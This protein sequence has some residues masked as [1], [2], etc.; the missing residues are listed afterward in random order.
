MDD[1]ER[2]EMARE[3]RTSYMQVRRYP[4]VVAY[5]P[6][7]LNLGWPAGEVVTG[8]TKS[9]S[10]G[11]LGLLLDD[12]IPLRTPVWVQV[13]QDEPLSGHIIWRD[14]PTPTDLGIRIAHGVAFDCPVEGDRIR[15]WASE[16]RRQ[17]HPR[18]Q[19]QFD[20]EFIQAGETR[21][22][23]CLNLSRAGMFIATPDPPRPGTEI[24][25]QFGVEDVSYPLSIPAKVVWVHGEEVAAS[26]ITGMGVKFLG[27]K[28]SAATF[29]ADVIDRGRRKIPASHDPFPSL[30][31]SG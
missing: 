11:G 29:I 1:R 9:I 26:A 25:L 8:K 31:P 10:A 22:G 21:P 23:S 28:P 6:T 24:L 4:R 18:R 13:A 2:E 14:R 27:L 16:S 20:L 12:M 3:P 19:V 7:T 15:Q 30:A 17:S 5:L